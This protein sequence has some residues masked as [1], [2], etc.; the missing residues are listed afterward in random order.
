MQI[1]AG[2]SGS[3]RSRQACG[4]YVS[5]VD[6]TVQ[7]G[8]PLKPHTAE[9]AVTLEGWICGGRF[10]QLPVSHDCR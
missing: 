7:L 1:A 5:P 9:G 4:L 3:L 6:E 10:T 2:P 8:P